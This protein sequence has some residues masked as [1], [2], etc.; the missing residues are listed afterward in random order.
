VTD[1][2]PDTGHGPGLLASLQR[3]TATLL[4]ILQTRVEI[5]ATEFEEERA[6]LQELLVFGIL[7]LFFVGVGLTLF[8]LFVVMLYWETQRLAVLGGLALFYL[9]LG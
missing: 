1:H 5:V 4:D 7:T 3:L 8:T 9:G 6:R 2:E